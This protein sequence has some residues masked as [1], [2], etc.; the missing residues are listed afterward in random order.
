VFQLL[1]RSAS[2]GGRDHLISRVI[3]GDLR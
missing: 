2:L 3:S 1:G